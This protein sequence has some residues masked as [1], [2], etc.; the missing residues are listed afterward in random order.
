MAEI[1][2]WINVKSCYISEWE[3]RQCEANTSSQIDLQMQTIQMKLRLISK[4]IPH[5]FVV[6][7]VH[8]YPRETKV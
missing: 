6:T 4:K 7:M 5:S 1:K 2:I 8:D 3:D